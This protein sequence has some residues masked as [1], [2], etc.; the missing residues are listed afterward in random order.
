MIVDHADRLHR[1]V[2]RGRA[3]ED[4]APRLQLLRERLRL[5]TGRLKVGEG[6]RGGTGIVGRERPDQLV[7]CLTVRVHLAG[8]LRVRDRRLDLLAVADD[9]GVAEQALDVLVVVPGDLLDVE[10]VE[11]ATEVLALAQD[12]EPGKARLERLQGEPLEQLVLAVQRPTPLGVVV[13]DVVGRAERP[14]AA[15]LPIRAGLD[16]SHGWYGGASPQPHRGTGASWGTSAPG[17]E[18]SSASR[19]P[20]STYA[21][22]AERHSGSVGSPASSAAT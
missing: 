5:R 6:L 1:R 4:E 11:G 17:W 12:R 8:G 19:V 13:L 16:A 3:D 9:P 18:F 7:E 22:K 15:R 2:D 10:A 20:H 21:M 14:P